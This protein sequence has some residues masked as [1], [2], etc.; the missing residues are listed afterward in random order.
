MIYEKLDLCKT[1][2]LLIFNVTFDV[3]LQK[4]GI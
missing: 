2:F 4:N 1:F 3:K